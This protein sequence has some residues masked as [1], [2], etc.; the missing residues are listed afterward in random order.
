MRVVLLGL[1]LSGCAMVSLQP[2]SN[3]MN[4]LKGQPVEAAFDKLGYPQ[5]HENIAGREVYYW[6]ENSDCEF[7]IVST[8]DGKVDKWSAVGSPA[9]CSMYLS[10]LRQ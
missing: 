3:G 7:N 2:F 9:G 1:V 5:R 6:S 10:G 4:G 8:P